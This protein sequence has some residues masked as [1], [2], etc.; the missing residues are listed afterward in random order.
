MSAEALARLDAFVRAGGGLIAILAAADAHYGSAL[1]RDRIGE[2]FLSHPPGLQSTVVRFADDL[3][4]FAALSGGRG[5]MVTDEL[6]DF[7]DNPRGR[8]RVIATLDETTYGSGRMGD[9]HPIAWCRELGLGRS[10]YTGL[11]HR[12]ELFED[13]LF[14]EHLARGLAWVAGR[15]TSC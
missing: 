10:W 8:V 13:P 9:D 15:G 5:W 1:Y 2:W 4:G 3:P 14:R 11:G 6:Y 7:E 12:P